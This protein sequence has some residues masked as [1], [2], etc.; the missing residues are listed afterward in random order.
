VLNKQL[1]M[2]LSKHQYYP[3]APSLR[4]HDSQFVNQSRGNGERPTI[5]R[6]ITFQGGPKHMGG[7]IPQKDDYKGG[8]VHTNQ[9]VLVDLWVR[10]NS[11]SPGYKA[12][13]TPM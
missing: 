1:Y 4:N 3:S 2:Q 9:A 10:M 13:W 12:Q 8:G 11:Y 6:L 7:C 5:D